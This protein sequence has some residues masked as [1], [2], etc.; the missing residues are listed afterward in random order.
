M[1]IVKL[2]VNFFFLER[3]LLLFHF[4]YYLII[5][6]TKETIFLCTSKLFSI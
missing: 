1:T 5:W 4:I 2:K 6:K 3:V